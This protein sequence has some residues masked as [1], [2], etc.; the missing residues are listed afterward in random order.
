MLRSRDFAT[1]TQTLEAKRA[2]VAQDIR[3]ETEWNRVTSKLRHHRSV[4]HTAHRGLGRRVPRVGRPIH[5]QRQAHA[6]TGQRGER[7]EVGV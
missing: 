5:R 1:L 4:D 6:L 3:H 7:H 2:R